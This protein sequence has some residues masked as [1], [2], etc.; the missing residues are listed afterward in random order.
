LWKAMELS[1]SLQ[2][3]DGTIHPSKCGEWRIASGIVHRHS[4]W[5]RQRKFVC[6][7]RCTNRKSVLMMLFERFNGPSTPNG[8]DMVIRLYNN[9]NLKSVGQFK[10][11]GANHYLG[12]YLFQNILRIFSKYCI[13]KLKEIIK[14]L[15]WPKKNLY[16]IIM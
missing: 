13:C 3:D 2:M 16:Y 11:I 9:V 6:L 7:Q 14:N 10:L 5:G 8:N 12:Q 15:L 1:T 4:Q